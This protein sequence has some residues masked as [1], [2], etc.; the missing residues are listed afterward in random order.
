M[1]R[2]VNAERKLSRL[3]DCIEVALDLAL[4]TGLLSAV[5]FLISITA[6]HVF[7]PGEKLKWTFTYLLSY[8]PSPA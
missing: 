3:R 8:L 6:R 2:C 5:G 1:T 7:G 4:I